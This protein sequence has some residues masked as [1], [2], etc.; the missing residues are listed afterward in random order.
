MTTMT[1][2]RT[3]T[4][5]T[6]VPV[7]RNQGTRDLTIL[8]VLD[9]VALGEYAMP[10]GSHSLLIGPADGDPERW[11]SISHAALSLKW[12]KH[13]AAEGYTDLGP[14]QGSRGGAPR[15]T[16]A[17]LIAYRTR[18]DAVRR[19][20]RSK[21]ITALRHAADRLRSQAWRSAFNSDASRDALGA[22]D[23]LLNSLYW[24]RAELDAAYA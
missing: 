14:A 16:L 19:D 1:T 12:L 10:A 6:T 22:A 3:L 5:G 13:L 7:E 23:V 17:S 2:A 21:A 18:E 20:P 4:P 15:V 11:R 9:G 8:A 24:L